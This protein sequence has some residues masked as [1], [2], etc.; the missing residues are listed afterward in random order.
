MNQS[1]PLSKFKVQV[2][3][4]WVI[5]QAVLV[6]LVQF[7]KLDAQMAEIIKQCMVYVSIAA[8]VLITGHTVTD[9]TALVNGAKGDAT[10]KV[11]A[12]NTIK[13]FLL[14]NI[15]TVKTPQDVENVI[16]KIA[17][18]ISTKQPPQQ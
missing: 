15:G 7:G 10:D 16:K 2:T 4:A 13:D 18:Q 3:I 9:I 12:V 1:N 8:G 5:V 6:L 17:D 14:Q 11:A